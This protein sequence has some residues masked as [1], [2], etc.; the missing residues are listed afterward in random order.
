MTIT[1]KI[2]IKK[3]EILFFFRFST[4]RIFHINLNTFEA[5]KKFKLFIQILKLYP[6]RNSLVSTVYFI[7]VSSVFCIHG[8][9][10]ITNIE[11]VVCQI[12]MDD[13]ESVEWRKKSDFSDFYSYG[14]FFSKNCQFL[15][16]FHDN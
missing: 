4:F 14:H 1:R 9:A 15:M 10:Y 12:Y 5:K 11:K 2:K 7:I 8:Y 16:N 3:S 13:A 6:S